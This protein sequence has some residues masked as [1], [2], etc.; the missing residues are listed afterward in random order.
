MP[1]QLLAEDLVLA[2]HAELIDTYGGSHGL[3]DRNLL[4]SALDR[5]ENKL[6]YEPQVTVPAL[7]ASLGWGLIK[8]H[9]FLDGN[10][11]IGLASVITF[12]DVNGYTFSV[13]T[14]D[15]KTMILRA[16]GSEIT[17]AEWSAWLQTA[18]APK[19]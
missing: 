12:L 19:S 16:A 7:A 18:A 15:V 11:S 1:I 5:I 8:N 10:K 4:L 6:H 14:D 17:E 3:R 2:I 9:V 13:S